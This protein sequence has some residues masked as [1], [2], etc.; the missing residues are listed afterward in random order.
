[1]RRANQTGFSYADLH[2]LEYI[3]EGNQ[4]PNFNWFVKEVI[5]DTIEDLFELWKFTVKQI[6]SEKTTR[7]L[8]NHELGTLLISCKTWQS[9]F[10][11]GSKYG[12][13]CITTYHNNSNP[14]I[15][16]ISVCWP[17]YAENPIDYKEKLEIN[18]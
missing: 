18:N 15:Y 14:N 10:S 8:F 9:Q 16:E 13:L 11:H 4:L 3:K 5:G 12:A 17:Q 7:E 2:K 1:M 6:G